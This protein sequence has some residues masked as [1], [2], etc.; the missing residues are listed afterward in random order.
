MVSALSFFATVGVVM[1]ATTI[2]LNMSVSNGYGLDAVSGTLNIGTTTATTINIG[3]PTGTTAI[4][5]NMTFPT[6]YGLDSSGA[7]LNIGTT[8][9]TTINIGSL[10]GLT[11]AGG[12]ITVPAAYG[13]D[14][15][16]TGVL[17]IGTT[18]ATRVN[19]GSASAPV[20]MANSSS[21]LANFGSGTTVSGLLWGTCAVNPQSITAA[22]SSA[23]STSCSATGMTSSYKVFVTPPNDGVISD[24]NWL[25]FKGASASTTAGYIEI[26]LFNAS[27][28]ASVDGP[29][30]TWSWMAIK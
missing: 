29:S 22:T 30:K 7:I 18:T 1:A 4:R 24:D 26:T 12:R 15:A 28:T 16:A 6:A 5:G 8:T 23:V 2:G 25:V 11:A 27:T 3:S 10:T 14:V 9:A 21:T 13:L 20:V 19:I 17:N